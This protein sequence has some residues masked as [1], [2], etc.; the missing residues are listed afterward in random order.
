VLFRS[1]QL[2][3]DP[4]FLLK[5][6]TGDEIGFM[7]MTLKQGSNV[8]RRLR[9]DMRIKGPEKWCTYDLV[10]HQDNA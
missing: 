2:Q 1:Q 10:L 5:V 4:D 7:A 6:V 9:E 8:L 3:E